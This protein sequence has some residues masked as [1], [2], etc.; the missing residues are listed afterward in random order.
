[1]QHER[2]VRQL[3]ETRGVVPASRPVEPLAVKPRVDRVRAGCPQNLREPVVVGAAAQGARP[4]TRR[5]RRRLVEE[6]ELGEA[7]GL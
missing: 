3:V 4:V 7:A 6:E 2:A 1:M 5:E